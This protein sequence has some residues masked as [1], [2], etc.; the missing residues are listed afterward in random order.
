MQRFEALVDA[1]F[2]AA[3]VGRGWM[4]EVQKIMRSGCPWAAAGGTS[5][6]EQVGGLRPCG[7]ISN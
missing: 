5:Y 1:E 6:E 7:A 3:G 2:A 4:S